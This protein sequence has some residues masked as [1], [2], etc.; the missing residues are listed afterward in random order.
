MNMAEIRKL[1]ARA[2]FVPLEIESGD[3]FYPN[4]IFEFNITKL[5]RY[6]KESP[7]KFR[8]EPVN[9]GDFAGE[10]SSINEPHM[11]SALST[12]PVIIAEIS[13]GRYNLIDGNH[14]MEQARRRGE[15]TIMGYKIGPRDHMRFITTKKGYSAYIEYWNEKI[16]QT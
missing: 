9:I 12:E 10:F 1:K 2:D 3:E 5:A 16:D 15:K 7:D 8:P 11:E 6:I 13:P 4:G 14:R